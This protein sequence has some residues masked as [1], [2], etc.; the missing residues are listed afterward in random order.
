M[1]LRIHFGT[2]QNGWL[3]VSVDSAGDRIEFVASDVGDD[4]LR[5]VIEAVHAVLCR[6]GERQVRWFLEP[7]HLTW[8]LERRRDQIKFQVTADDG[9][10]VA[11]QGSVAE[12][13]LPIWRS[14][15]RLQADQIWGSRD[16]GWRHPF[17]SSAMQRLSEQVKILKASGPEK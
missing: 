9:S 16:P 1:R 11:S 3:F 8:T 5:I 14:L 2:P 4:S 15:R 13:S 10:I 17:P 12:I 7:D 6:D